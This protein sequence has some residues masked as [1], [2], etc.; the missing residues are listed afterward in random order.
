MAL[1]SGTSAVGSNMLGN[2]SECSSGIPQPTN[3]STLLAFLSLHPLPFINQWKAL[4]F[5]F[6]QT[7]CCLEP[8]HFK[9]FYLD[10]CS[11]FLANVSSSDFAHC[12]DDCPNSDS[13]AMSL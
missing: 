3:H 9:T 13:Q 1:T 4:M 11:H 12:Q 6:S 8:P 2:P 7:P 10:R 5:F